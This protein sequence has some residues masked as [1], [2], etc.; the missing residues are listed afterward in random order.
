[1]KSNYLHDRYRRILAEIY[2]PQP[3]L[4]GKG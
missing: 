4:C 3:D 1:M 2:N